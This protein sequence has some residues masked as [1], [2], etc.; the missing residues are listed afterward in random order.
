VELNEV[1]YM[2]LKDVCS[3]DRTWLSGPP[4]NDYIA[5]VVL[6]VCDLGRGWCDETRGTTQSQVVE[7]ITSTNQTKATKVNH[8]KPAAHVSATVPTVTICT[9]GVRRLLGG[10]PGGEDCRK[11]GRGRAKAQPLP[12]EMTTETCLATP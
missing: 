9:S 12:Q 4:S 11:D 1:E 3:V 2:Y 8:S 10:L 6:V 7:M 5:D